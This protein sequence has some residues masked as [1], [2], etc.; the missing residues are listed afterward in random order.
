M[1]PGLPG[2][3]EDPAPLMNMGKQTHQTGQYTPTDAY[4]YNDMQFAD[5]GEADSSFGDFG[6]GGSDSPSLPSGG[7][8]PQGSIG[9][10]MSLLELA[11]AF[12]DGGM[13]TP[14]HGSKNVYPDAIK[15]RL[16]KMGG[17]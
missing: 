4:G 1:S 7:K 12:S 14:F 15:K 17:C 16:S 10:L 5:G 3:G 13:V 9:G 11:G 6:G 2:P 8:G